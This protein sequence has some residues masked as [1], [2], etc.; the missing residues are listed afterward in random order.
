[1]NART[2]IEVEG[3]GTMRHLNNWQIRAIRAMANR[4]RRA[5]AELAFGLGMTVRQFRS[6]SIPVQK[7]AREAHNR[8]YSP[9]AFSASQ[10]P[11]TRSSDSRG[12]MRGSRT[13]RR[14]LLAPN[15]SPSSAKSRTAISALGSRRRA[16]Y[17]TRRPSASSRWRGRRRRYR[18]GIWAPSRQKI[19]YILGDQGWQEPCAG[20]SIGKDGMVFVVRGHCRARRLPPVNQDYRCGRPPLKRAVDRNKKGPLVGAFPVTYKALRRRGA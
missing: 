7:A 15:S 19:P 11:R 14:R 12:L 4:E 3:I 8:L 20:R 2:E 6:L 9:Q 18:Q 1:M 10:N 13:R 5:D 17:R 16:G